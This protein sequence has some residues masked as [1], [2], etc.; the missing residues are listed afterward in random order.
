MPNLVVKQV[1]L[2]ETRLLEGARLIE[3]R[4]VLGD[5]RSV[6]HQPRRIVVKTDFWHVKLLEVQLLPHQLTPTDAST[7]GIGDSQLSIY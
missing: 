1:L 3:D 2:E 4:R 7:G 6:D 5:L